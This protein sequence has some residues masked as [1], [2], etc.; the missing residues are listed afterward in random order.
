MS[1]VHFNALFCLEVCKDKIARQIM[2]RVFPQCSSKF[3]LNT[4]IR[5]L[6]LSLL[7]IIM[8]VF[9]EHAEFKLSMEDIDIWF[10]ALSV[11]LFS[12]KN[13]RRNLNLTNIGKEGN[14]LFV[15]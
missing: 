13:R 2:S 9:N 4:S 8:Q 7:K 12:V 14:V 5:F 3:T 15:V 11:L 6:I 10:Y 1:A